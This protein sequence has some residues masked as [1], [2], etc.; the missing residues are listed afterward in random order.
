[1]QVTN[2]IPKVDC[3][4]A[5]SVPVIMKQGQAEY[6]NEVFQKFRGVLSVMLVLTCLQCGSPATLSLTLSLSTYIAV[7]M[8]LSLGVQ[9]AV[10]CASLSIRR[11]L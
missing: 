11:M 6:D 9:C 2:D 3:S 7:H 5:T 8:H 10:T 4:D 1:M